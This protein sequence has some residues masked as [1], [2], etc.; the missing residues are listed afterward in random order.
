[1]SFLSSTV[2]SWSTRVLKKLQQL[3][4]ILQIVLRYISH[5][6]EINSPE[7]QHLG[8]YRRLLWELQAGTQRQHRMVTK[9]RD[10]WWGI[11]VALYFRHNISVFSPFMMEAN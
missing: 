8:G 10:K 5:I 11:I 4:H 9:T 1:M 2:T 7:E 3:A 6:Y